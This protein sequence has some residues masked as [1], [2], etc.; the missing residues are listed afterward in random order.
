MNRAQ[1][2]FLHLPKGTHF[3]KII[4]TEYGKENIYVSP[5]GKKHS[6]PM[7]TDKITLRTPTR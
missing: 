4:D 2:Y 1:K 6:I 7:I 5:D 3:E